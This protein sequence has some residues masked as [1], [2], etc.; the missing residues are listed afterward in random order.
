MKALFTTW[1]N[2]IAP[3]FDVASQA[4]LVTAENKTDLTKEK[5]TLPCG[6]ALEKIIFIAGKGINVLVCGAISRPVY[7][8]VEAHG[9]KINPFVSGQVKDVIQA[10]LEDRLNDSLFTMPGCNC[11]H[12]CFQQRN[13][14]NRNR[15]RNS[16]CK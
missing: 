7:F 11:R 5:I 1:H 16:G 14:G 13:R 2:R 6:P 12:R 3:V 15:R 4:L 9:I 10:W 8:A